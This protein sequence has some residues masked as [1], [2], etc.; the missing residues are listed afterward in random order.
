MY[1]NDVEYLY[2]TS[3]TRTEHEIWHFRCKTCANKKEILTD[4]K[5]RVEID[6]YDLPCACEIITFL[7]K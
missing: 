7:A 6:V 5:A 2:T 1:L 3:G 4:N